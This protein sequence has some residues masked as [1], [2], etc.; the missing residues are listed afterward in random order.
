[1]AGDAALDLP[2]GALLG[3][4]NLGS[5]VVVVAERGLIRWDASLAEGTPV[6]MGTRLGQ[7]ARPEASQPAGPGTEQDRC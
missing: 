4:F 5:T 2:A 7:T 1:L 6:R 3:Q